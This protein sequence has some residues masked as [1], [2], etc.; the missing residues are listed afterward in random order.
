[1]SNPAKNQRVEAKREHKHRRKLVNSTRGNTPSAHSNFLSIQPLV[2]TMRHDTLNTLSKVTI[3]RANTNI[4]V[5]TRLLRLY[6]QR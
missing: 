1:M 6:G 3:P 2:T 5:T 4:S